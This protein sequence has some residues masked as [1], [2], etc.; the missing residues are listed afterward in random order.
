MSP[1]S[2]SSDYAVTKLTHRDHGSLL[3][4][5]STHAAQWRN[6]GTALGFAQGEMDN[7]HSNTLLQP[8]SPTSWLS[9]MLSQWLEWAPCNAR[10]SRDFA[11]LEGLRE[12]LK[13]ANLGA[14]AHDLHL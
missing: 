4:Q 9:K 3:R 11:T 7:I 13:A 1:S 2:V 5:L 6:I 12:A 14:T 8:G 10:G